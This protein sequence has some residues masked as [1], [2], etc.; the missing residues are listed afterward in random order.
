MRVVQNMPLGPTSSK[1]MTF[2]SSS[3][4]SLCRTHRRANQGATPTLRS[5]LMSNGRPSC[6]EIPPI[7]K[8][9]GGRFFLEDVCGETDWPHCILYEPLPHPHDRPRRHPCQGCR[10]THFRDLAYLSRG[11]HALWTRKA[12]G[13]HHTARFLPDTLVFR[14][15]GQFIRFCGSLLIPST[16]T[17]GLTR[18][19]LQRG[20]RR[21]TG[22]AENAHARRMRDKISSSILPACLHYY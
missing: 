1:T 10:Q 7:R 17:C 8:V 11:S 9:D 22:G 13:D 16:I 19:L 12:N 18:Y 15:A 5:L 2:G 14:V 3:C 21:T 20:I 4:A 6:T